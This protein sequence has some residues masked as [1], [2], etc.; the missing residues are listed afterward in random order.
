M[1]TSE[2]GRPGTRPCTNDIGPSN[3]RKLGTVNERK[4]GMGKENDP[5]STRSGSE[6][7]RT[8]A[9]GERV[10]SVIRAGRERDVMSCCVASQLEKWTCSG[11]DMV[12]QLRLRCCKRKVV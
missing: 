6:G 1:M 3:F 9:Q 4:G 7:R 2:T 12:S 8:G 10:N 5:R 11:T